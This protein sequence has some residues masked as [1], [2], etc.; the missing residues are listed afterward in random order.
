M[1]LKRGDA[2]TTKYCDYHL[3]RAGVEPMW[4]DPANKFG[5]KLVIRL[6]KGIASRFWENAVSF[7]FL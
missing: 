3:F 2:L 1:C 6:R 5:G 4:E 7:F